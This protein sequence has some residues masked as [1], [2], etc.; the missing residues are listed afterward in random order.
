MAIEANGTVSGD[1]I[2]VLGGIVSPI[3]GIGPLTWNRQ[4]G[5]AG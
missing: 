5:R 1:S 2:N 4:S 3:D